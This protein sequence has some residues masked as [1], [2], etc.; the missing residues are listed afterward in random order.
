LETVLILIRLM[1]VWSLPAST[2][3][4]F[5]CSD[6]SFFLFGA[7][8]ACEIVCGMNSSLLATTRG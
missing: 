4:S 1:R 8:G 7:R 3:R 2:W 5:I 6:I